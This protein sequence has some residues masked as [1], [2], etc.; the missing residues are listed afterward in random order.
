MKVRI[1]PLPHINKNY[2]FEYYLTPVYN[3]DGKVIGYS[4]ADNG[5]YGS[6]IFE[7]DLKNGIVEIITDI[8]PKKELKKFS[9]I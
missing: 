8:K 4:Y 6:K 5:W 7:T 2:Y 9:L 1:I 3:V